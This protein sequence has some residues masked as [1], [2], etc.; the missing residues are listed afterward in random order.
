LDNRFEFHS[1]SF[2][3]RERLQFLEFASEE[4]GALRVKN[5]GIRNDKTIVIISPPNAICG[6]SRTI[7]D[8][9]PW[10]MAKPAKTSLSGSTNKSTS[11]TRE[12]MGIPTKPHRR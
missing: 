3:E 8:A 9:S 7:Q 4:R 1:F 12:K 6:A 10:Y 5:I 11:P 2:W